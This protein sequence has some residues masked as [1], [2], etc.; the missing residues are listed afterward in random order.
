[1]NA[2]RRYDG[3]NIFDDQIAELADLLIGVEGI[4]STYKARRDKAWVRKIGN[5][6]LRD[7]LLRMPDIQIY[8]IVTLIFEDKS[9]LDIRNEKNMSPS[10]IRREIRSMHDTL[11]RKM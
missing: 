2:E 11:I 9:I 6:D 1:M 4:K 5:E 3:M 7:A 8:I 10:G